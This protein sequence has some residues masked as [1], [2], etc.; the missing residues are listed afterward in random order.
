MD[1]SSVVFGRCSGPALL[2]LF[3]VGVLVS[4]CFPKQPGKRL[5][6]FPVEA[7]AVGSQAPEFVATTPD[8]KVARLSSWIGTR[9]VV[10]QLGSHSCPVY[11]YRRHS[12]GD[13]WA[14]YGERA[15][16]LV[17][18]TLEAH[19][20]GATSPYS[21]EEWNPLINSWLG[22][23]LSPV[24][25]LEERQERA[26]WSRNAL[27]LPVTML[28]DSMDDSVWR[29]YGRASSPAF[30]IDLEGRIVLRQAWL[31]PKPI[32]RALDRLLGPST[33]HSARNQ[34]TN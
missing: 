3:I 17:V 20:E 16:F 5:T 1:P 26:R 22:V 15:H 2:G 28:V 13:L 34:G 6:H 29:A 23:N 25:G 32:R 21:D 24:S 11:R 7:P 10:L 4:G 33:S 18:Y 19:P 30:V 27:E 8:G 12:M 9:P 14:D 31:D